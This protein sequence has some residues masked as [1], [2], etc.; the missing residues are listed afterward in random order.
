[1]FLSEEKDATD[2]RVGGRGERERVGEGARDEE[3]DP[4][5][6]TEVARTAGFR[7]E[8]VEGLLMS[9]DI[10][11]DFVLISGNIYH[12]FIDDVDSEERRWPTRLRHDVNHQVR[13]SALTL[14]VCGSNLY[15]FTSDPLVVDNI[16]LKIS[17]QG[18][19]Q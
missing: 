7:R 19:I 14:P 1:M 18:I 5:I 9:F 15:F 3:R 16:L 11:Y 17:L 2:L 13:K 12:T 4:G 6:D 8:G 10:I